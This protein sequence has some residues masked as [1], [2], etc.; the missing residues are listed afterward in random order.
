MVIDMFVDIREPQKILNLLK[1]REVEFEARMLPIGD[2]M[3]G[4]VCIERKDIGDLMSSIMTGH[5]QKQLLQMEENFARPYL[6]ISGEYKSLAFKPH[7]RNITVAH[8]NGALAHL[9]RYPKLK[10]FQTPNDNQLVDLVIRIMDKSFDGKVVTVM[11]TELMRNTLQNADIKL[12][13]LCAIPGIGLEK[14]KTLRNNLHIL[15]LN[16]DYDI[17]KTK[18]IMNIEGFGETTAKKVLN[19]HLL[20]GKTKQEIRRKLAKG[21]KEIPSKGEYTDVKIAEIMEKV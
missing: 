6:I 12:C 7:F 15:L 8:Y 19:V 21:I 17:C 2:F 16:K 1:K 3:K 14:A 20:L 11:D 18:D 10:V 4:D 5:L 9:I 13:M